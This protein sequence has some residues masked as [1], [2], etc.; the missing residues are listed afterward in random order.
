MEDEQFVARLITKESG[1]IL[2]ALLVIV[3]VAAYFGLKRWRG[4]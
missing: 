4:K 3:A 1:A 2:L